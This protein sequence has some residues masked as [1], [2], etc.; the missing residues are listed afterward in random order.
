LKVAYILA[1]GEGKRFGGDKLVAIVDGYTSI[2]RIAG[3]LAESGFDMVYAVTRDEWRCKVYTSLAPLDGCIYDNPP[4]PGCSG[5]A[6]AIYTALV[7]AASLS[8]TMAAIVPGDMPWLNWTA[9]SMI[10]S[11]APCPGSA[12]V[13]HADGYLESLVQI[14]R[15]SAILAAAEGIARFCRL[16]GGKARPTDALRSTPKLALTATLM[17]A[18]SPTVF[19][20]INTREN[21]RARQPKSPPLTRT[22]IVVEPPASRGDADICLT[23]R[24][25]AEYYSKLGVTH[26]ADQAR[27]DLEQLCPNRLL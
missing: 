1:G 27:R 17:A 26:L 21:L 2:S 18:C 3:V 11:A 24:R 6:A 5:P 20:H 7:H 14:H 16:R 4:A 8:A 25:E 10:A 19:A 23:L 15:G 22:V 13:M 12:T 9:L